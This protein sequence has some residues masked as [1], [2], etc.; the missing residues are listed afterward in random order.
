MTKPTILVCNDDGYYAEGIQR[1]RACLAPLGRVITVAPAQDCSGVSH[2][3]TL[4]TALRLREVAP[5]S[6]AV[7][8]T[9]V[10]CILLALHG[11][12]DGKIPDLLVSGVNHGPNLGEDTAYSGTVAAAYQGFL[13]GVPSFAVSTG[14]AAEDDKRFDNACKVSFQLARAHLEGNPYLKRAVWNINV[15]AEGALKGIR[16]VGQ[17]KR[18]F[19]SSVVQREDPRG[20]PY[21]WIGPYFPEFD[22]GENTDYA[23]YRDGYVA[24]TPLKIEMTHREV[25]EES[26]IALQEVFQEIQ[27]AST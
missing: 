23:V 20:L 7:S 3:I 8:G 24:M 19:K 16:V 13:H 4:H 22:R 5:D 21:Y 12:L 17:D 9:P 10:D 15:P 18:S 14:R 26:P 6:F 11:V 2:K 25:L 1:L 27:K